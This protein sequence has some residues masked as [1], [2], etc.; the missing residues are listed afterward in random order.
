M[1]GDLAA[2]RGDGRDIDGVGAAD[3]DEPDLAIGVDP[4]RQLRERLA[5][6]VLEH[7]E[8]REGG[9]GRRRE[10]QDEDEQQGPG[11][12]GARLTH[13]GRGE[14]AHQHVGQRRRADHQAEHERE[15]VQ[16]VVAGEG[17]DMRGRRRDAERRFL[18][19]DL[20]KNLAVGELRDR[21]AEL[22]GGE[23]DHRDQIGDDQND[24]LSDLRPGNG[25]HAAQHR[26]DQDADEADEDRQFEAH[27]QQAG[28]DQAG[29]DDLRH[30]IGE[31]AA[32]QHDDASDARRVAA[33]AERQEVRHGVAAELAQIGRDQRRHQHVAAGP[34]EDEGETV[35]AE[36]IE[37]AG[38]ADEGGRRH[39]VR[40]GRHAV[41]EG[42]H[43]AAGDVVFV[44]LH[45]ARHDADRSIDAD[46]E[47]DEEIAENVVGDAG[48]LQHADENDK[49]D[50]AACIDTVDP[51]EIRGEVALL[52]SCRHG[53]VPPQSSSAMPYLRSTLSWAL[54]NQKSWSTNTIREPWAAM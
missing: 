37:R 9:I 42:R 31:G 47:G 7:L 19:L 2:G 22:L 44:D 51:A 14:V 53:S 33:E 45:G 27:A 16:G 5:D 20:G 36:Q 28:A 23:D 43:L 34:A 25:A 26:A 18:G 11:H 40:R 46:G 49:G 13:G 21:N 39:P 30:H 1:P 8:L 48:T 52:S 3:L 35:I 38:H 12:G 4:A 6:D 50:E 41:V 32:H 15:E 24:V 17:H 10:V 29:A 54:A